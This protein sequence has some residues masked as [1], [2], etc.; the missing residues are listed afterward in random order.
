MEWTAFDHGKTVGTS[1]SEGGV[2]RRDEEH[3][4][5]A[6]ITLEEGGAAAPWSI[7]CGIYG[8]MVHTR[9]LATE[10]EGNQEFELM[11]TALEE[12]LR[13]FPPEDDATAEKMS[14]ASRAIAAFVER[15]D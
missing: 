8:W 15:F 3:D 6:R 12:V 14:A 10:D 1:G 11:K 13:I 9:F 5:G 4:S 2:I 7:T